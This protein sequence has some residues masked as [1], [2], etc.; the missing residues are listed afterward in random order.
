MDRYGNQPLMLAIAA[1]LNASHTEAAEN[2][3]QVLPEMKI[4]AERDPKFNADTSSSI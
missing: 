1:I 3:P 4:K 2:R